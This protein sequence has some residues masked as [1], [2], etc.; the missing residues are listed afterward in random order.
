MPAA[1]TAP[2]T[3]M[4]YAPS[5]PAKIAEFPFVQVEFPPVE[6]PSLQIVPVPTPFVQVP[7]TGALVVPPGPAQN[8]V[9]AA[10]AGLATLNKIAMMKLA[11]TNV[12][13][14][15]LGI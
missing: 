12:F 4:P 9:I 6:L 13:R 2:P 1:V 8:W 15:L 11:T 7:L 5:A 3:L 14:G 10:E